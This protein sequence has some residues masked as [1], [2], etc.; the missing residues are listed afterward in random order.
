MTSEY[1]A[2]SPQIL[3]DQIMSSTVPKSERE[4]WATREIERLR[5]KCDRQ[6]TILRHLS[7]DRFAKTYFIHA[8]LGNKDQN[9]MPEKLLVV[10]EYGC[11]F[12]YV[13]ER[14]DKIMGP[15]W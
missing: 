2:T 1:Q 13:Y 3:E 10:P 6:A 8:E 11:D 14:T 7:P 4:W 12:S 15:E 9:G 5:K